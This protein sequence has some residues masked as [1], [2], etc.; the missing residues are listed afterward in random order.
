MSWHGS[1]R[2][3]TAR[4]RST[5]RDLSGINDSHRTLPPRPT[6]QYGRSD[7]PLTDVP[8]L[9]RTRSYLE[10]TDAFGQ[11]MKYVHRDK[12]QRPTYDYEQDRDGR[13]YSRDLYTT[14]DS[15]EDRVQLV[16]QMQIRRSKEASKQML[17]GVFSNAMAILEQFETRESPHKTLE[18]SFLYIP[19]QRG[20]SDED[21]R[22]ILE[23]QI[24]LFETQTKSCPAHVKAEV[25]EELR[26]KLLDWMAIRA[27][28]DCNIADTDRFA[29][30]MYEILATGHTTHAFHNRPSRPHSAAT[31]RESMPHI[32]GG[33]HSARQLDEDFRTHEAKKAMSPDTRRS[34]SGNAIKAGAKR[35]LRC[36]HALESQLATDVQLF[37][38]GSFDMK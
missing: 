30:K 17:F 18:K 24:L 26:R 21:I 32:L 33:L 3:V 12:L 22:S 37:E 20:K 27:D 31:I 8:G 36:N 4:E 14:Y 38:G 13:S 6:S 15:Y 35:I 1:K 34:R 16:E 10:R 25:A 7:R 28:N 9:E 2:P 29:A 5:R 11:A 19:D 23:T